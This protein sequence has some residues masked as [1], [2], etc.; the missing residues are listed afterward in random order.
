MLTITLDDHPS[1]IIDSLK[2][3]KAK[4][5]I[6]ADS[7]GEASTLIDLYNVNSIPLNYLIDKDGVIQLKSET[8]FN[9]L[10][11]LDSIMKIK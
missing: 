6:V 10:P 7:L 9:L 4:W 1:E 8:G 5:D 11:E 2:T 3:S